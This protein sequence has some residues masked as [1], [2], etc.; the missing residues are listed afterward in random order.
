[1]EWKKCMIGENIAQKVWIKLFVV[2]LFT[3]VLLLIFSLENRTA[4]MGAYFGEACLLFSALGIF[5][6][7][8]YFKPFLVMYITL[9]WFVG[10]LSSPYKNMAV[11]SN[12]ESTTKSETKE[13]QKIRKRKTGCVE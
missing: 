4:Y 8:R 11:E 7:S 3:C 6:I 2:L 9:I 5:L 12:N 13:T 10:S 1:M